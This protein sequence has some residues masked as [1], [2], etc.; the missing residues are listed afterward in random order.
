MPPMH[1]NGSDLLPYS[2]SQSPNACQTLTALLAVA[3]INKPSHHNGALA[4]ARLAS[5]PAP[6]PLLLENPALRQRVEHRRH[7]RLPKCFAL[8][9]KRTRRRRL[10]RLNARE[11]S[12]MAS[13]TQGPTCR[14][15]ERHIA[16][17]AETTSIPDGGSGELRDAT[18]AEPHWRTRE[19]VP[20][21]A[22]SRM[23]PAARPLAK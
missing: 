20:A 8:G 10:A 13:T 19:L 1:D 5:S 12:K 17:A 3:D 9:C 4:K 7:A 11:R 18:S 16:H 23:A 21:K 2:L 14:P 22:Y 6:A 15:L